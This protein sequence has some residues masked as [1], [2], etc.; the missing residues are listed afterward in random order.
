M[1]LVN[2]LLQ[3]ILTQSGSIPANGGTAVINVT[4][5]SGTLARLSADVLLAGHDD[6]S[7]DLCSGLPAEIVVKCIASVA[8]AVT[9]VVGSANPQNSNSSGLLA[10]RAVADE[11]VAVADSTAVW[12]VPGGGD[13]ARLTITNA[14]ATEDCEYD[15]VIYAHS[16]AYAFT[17]ADLPLAAWYR[18][19]TGVSVDGSGDNQVRTWTEISQSPHDPTKDLQQAVLAT[20]PVILRQ[21]PNYNNRTTIQFAGAQFLASP[22]WSSAQN[23]PFTV[24]IVGNDD[25][26]ATGGEVYWTCQG[27]GTTFAQTG[28]IGHGY[29]FNCGVTLNDPAALSASPRVEGTVGNGAASVIYD[30][31]D[32]QAASGNVGAGG[33]TDMCVGVDFALT[34]DFLTGTIAEIVVVTGA[35]TPGQSSALMAYFGARYGIVIGP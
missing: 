7:L 32:T 11:L 8:T 34:G 15:V 14:H 23:Q 29:N 24:W 3:P 17:P 31:A 26:L 30:T 4:L 33:V 22:A 1:S 6:G 9:A 25:G 35:M 13:E 21:D 5:Q 27:S 10:A 20:Q 19:D 28:I 2:R 12:S 16:V 18:A